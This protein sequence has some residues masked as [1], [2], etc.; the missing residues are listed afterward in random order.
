MAEPF[1][2]SLLFVISH[3]RLDAGFVVDTVAAVTEN[4]LP[5]LVTVEAVPVVP[6]SRQHV[7]GGKAVGILLNPG[8]GALS[9]DFLLQFDEVV[10]HGRV[11]EALRF[12]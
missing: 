4:H 6:L 1:D 5:T 7:G 8:F 3:G 11:Q 10:F 2:F 12:V 9:P